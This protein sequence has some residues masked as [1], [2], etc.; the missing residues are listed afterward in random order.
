MD[1]KKASAM[2]LATLLAACSTTAEQGEPMASAPTADPSAGQ[3]W[4]LTFTGE[5]VSRAVFARDDREEMPV[6]EY[7]WSAIGRLDMGDSHCTA[8]LIGPDLILT[9]AHCV[10]TGMDDGDSGPAGIRLPQTVRFYP[11]FRPGQVPMYSAG[12][13]IWLDDLIFERAVMSNPVGAYADWAIMRLR[14]PLGERYGWIEPAEAAVQGEVSLGGYSGDYQ[15]G[16]NPLLHRGC[17][18]RMEGDNS[19]VMHDCDMTAGASGSPLIMFDGTRAL[20]AALNSAEYGAHVR[21]A[22]FA[23]K[24]E[25]SEDTHNIAVP[26]ENFYDQVASIPPL[27]E[28]QR[29]YYLTFCNDQD[30]SVQVTLAHYDDEPLLSFGPM[31]IPRDECSEIHMGNRPD[32]DFFISIEGSGEVSQGEHRICVN[33]G[34]GHLTELGDDCSDTRQSRMFTELALPEAGQ[35]VMLSSVPMGSRSAPSGG[36]S[37]KQPVAPSGKDGG[38][39]QGG[40]PGGQPESNQPRN[41]PNTM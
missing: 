13:R 21:D 11:A 30:V 26:V 7:P 4:D 2:L 41:G 35:P 6:D 16:R 9:N 37:G 5:V 25:F 3:A 33:P 8:S 10:L 34:Q 22:R 38:G 31:H 40:Q 27:Q 23:G 28:G 12:Q 29:D 20:I 15:G 32:R 24:L 18:I 19:E 39:Q 36:G 14:Q 17:A 1:M